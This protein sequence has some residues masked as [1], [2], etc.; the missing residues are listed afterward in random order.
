MSGTKIRRYVATGIIYLALVASV[1]GFN[2]IRARTAAPPTQPEP[3]KAPT[4]VSDAKPYFSLTTNRSYSPNESA[5]L[6]AN[7]KNV[8]YLDFRV[9]RVKDPNKFFKQL[10][11]PHEMGEKEKEQIS[12]GYGASPSL[13]D[14]THRLK[15]SL[16][17]AIKDFVRA[18]LQR[19]HREAFNQKYRKEPPAERTPLNVADYAR[20][21]LLNPDQK[22]KDWREKLPALENEYDSRLIP[23]GKLDSGVYLI[24]GVNEGLRAYSIAIVTNLT[25]IEKTNRHG[26]VMVY[27]V[28]RKTGAPH[29]GVSVEVTNAKN[30]LATGQTD[31][32]GIYKT[33]VKV[34][35]KPQVPQEDVNPEEQQRNSFLI[36]GRERDNFV[37]SDVD[38]FYFGGEGGAGGEDD[39]LTGEDVTSYIYTDRPIYRP[40]QTVFFKGILRQWTA[41]GYKLLDSKTAKVTIEDPN[42]GKIFEQQLPLSDRGT[43]SGQIDVGDEAPLGSYN[44]TASIGEASASGYFEV[45]EYKKPEFKVTVKGPPA[46]VPVGEKVH[47]TINANYFFGAPVTNADVH[48]YVYKQRYYHWWWSGDDSDDFDDAAG[49]GNEGDDEEDS[50]YYGND[51]V[52]EGDATLNARGDAVVEF[53]VPEPDP[54]EEW[55][56]SYR[57]EAQVT[58]ASRREMQGAAS[59]IG[60][61]G[62]TVADAYPE[63]YL[64]YQGDPAKIRVKTADYAGKPVSEKVTLKFI[65]QSWERQSKWEENNGYKY[66]TVDYILHERELGTGEV[67]TDNEGNATYNFTVPSP[68]SIYVKTIV[69]EDGREVVNRGGSFWAPDKMGQWADFSYQDYDEKSIKLVPDQKSYKPGQTAHVLALLPTDQAHLLVTTELSEVLTARQINSTGRSIVIDVPIDKKYAPNVYLDVSFVKNNDMYTQ[70]QIIGVP[71]RDKMLKLDV[72]PNKSEFKPRDVASYTIVARN[73]DGSPAANTEVSLG[74]VDEA[75]YSVAPETA[76]NIKREFYGR[77]FNEVQTSLAIHYTFTGYGGEKNA[78]LAKNKSAYQLADFKNENSY[79]EPTIRKEFKDTAF[80]QPDVVTGGDGKATVSFKLPDNLTTWRATARGVTA[81]TR[82]G[83]AVQKTI[84]RKDVIMRLEMPRFLTEGDT[85]T[86][87]GVVHNFLKSDKSTRISLEL[88]GAQLLDS[89][90]STVMIRP[91]GEQRI[92]WRVQAN[93]VGKLTL[94]AKALTDTE[95]DAVEMTMDIVPHG[96]RQ[97]AGNTTTVTQN[98]ADQ[99]FNLDVPG[100]ANAEARALRIEVSPSI[101]GALFGALDYLTSYPYGC[102]EQTMSSFLPNIVVAQTLKDIPTAKI[103]ASNDLDNK[104]KKGLDRLYAYQ[105]DDGGWGWWKDDKTD[106]FMTA[107]VVDG[108]TMASRAGYQIDDWRRTQ[109]RQKL[110][111]LLTAGKNDNGNPIDEETRAYMIYAFI[112]SSDG[113]VQFLDELYGKRNNLGSYGRALLA[114]ALQ[115]RK[116]GRAQEIAKLIEG[117]VKQDE[118][119]AHWQTARVNDY[120]RDVYLDA[121]AT[122]LS[123]KALAQIDPGSSLLPKAARWLVKNREK[124][125]YWIS[126]KE[127]AFAIYGLTDYLK[128]SKELTPN[129]TFEVYLNGVKVAGQSVGASDAANAQTVTVWKKGGE[130]ASSNQIRIVKH[131]QGALYVSSALEYFTADENV[132]A[133]SSGGLKITREYLRLH[134]SDDPN[135]K[136]SWKVEPLTGELRSGDLIVVR[137]HLTGPRAQ[138]VMIEDPIPAGAEQVARASGLFLNYTLGNW[139]DWYS[140][141]EFRD[142]RTAIFMNYFDGDAKLQY[143]MRVEVPGEF[144]IAPARA[145]LM[146]QPTVQANT[147]NDRLRILDK[148]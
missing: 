55:D 85:V 81:D 12:Q 96:L 78:D 140:N 93:T 36:M 16:Y 126:T 19:D 103:R 44:I 120:G 17:G 147:A 128:V 141:R 57:L 52:T 136:S 24:E 47:F 116:D 145:E 92:D 146:Y 86:I 94:L 119:E 80:W 33:D 22:V 9:Y 63:R 100:R 34:P 74:I 89:P 1:L 131:G 41:N 77:R 20:V 3:D 54:A 133:Q 83:S 42:N 138:Y 101:A 143:A 39:V 109:G 28:D 115:E 125:Y 88:N 102:T 79:A 58:D 21:P 40:A 66:E 15:V 62:K 7:Y 2:V 70:T 53:E 111:A 97:T 132:A 95:S 117:A 49:P 4:L 69:N 23:L 84:A 148:N 76:A 8:E 123:L 73:E 6:W 14:R 75:I 90:S 107:Y 60:T 45:Q 72:V 31:K 98:D 68:G 144:K 5:R 10:D 64:Y 71:A 11:D 106:P 124:G 82:V 135:G 37:I 105:H 113:D 99:S 121:E 110:S 61:R 67:S 25:M 118:F 91:N 27:I 127:T 134:V 65:E 43:F 50:G 18:H 26:Q 130:I 142:N 108:L 32:D 104:V 48:Y 38:S 56:Y 114:L 51:L 139:C 137:L 35:E 29:E 129:Y 87:S 46:F 30:T 112:E 13:L 59:F 122:A